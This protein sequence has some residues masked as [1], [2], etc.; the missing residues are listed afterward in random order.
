MR[1]YTVFTHKLWS[2]PVK[3]AGTE[4]NA[5]ITGQLGYD[6][7][8]STHL[9]EEVV[10]NKGH[11]RRH[12][13]PPSSQGAEYKVST[14]SSPD[15]HHQANSSHRLPSIIT[16]ANSSIAQKH[17]SVTMKFS[18][19]AT[20]LMAALVSAQPLVDDKVSADLAS[21]AVTSELAPQLVAEPLAE[22]DLA[23][24]ANAVFTVFKSPGKLRQDR[25]PHKE[26]QLLTL[27]AHR[28]LG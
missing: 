20:G 24:R 7:H 1:R 16:T 15:Y 18:Y 12:R 6:V 13:M 2:R 25:M 22:R 14:F 26:S 19:I 28:L 21:G 27:M 4:L 5:K 23:K 3:R 11:G 9:V 17:P 8:V 10:V